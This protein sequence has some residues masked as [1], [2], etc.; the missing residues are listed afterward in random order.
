MKPVDIIRL[1]GKVDKRALLTDLIKGADIPLIEQLLAP[2]WKNLD[3]D[4]VRTFIT[5]GTA[6][7]FVC[8]H[9]A[10]PLDKAF[11]GAKGMTISEAKQAFKLNFFTVG[12][13]PLASFVNGERVREE[14]YRLQGGEVVEFK[15][16]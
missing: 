10:C 11:D 8:S 16:P 3:V 4:Y 1:A 14:D 7:R 6:V 12:G 9:R 13:A 15:L 5:D 2:M